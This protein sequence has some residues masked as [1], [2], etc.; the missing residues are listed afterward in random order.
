MATL[1]LRGIRVIEMGF[2]VA[3]PFACALLADFGAEVIKIEP[4]GAGDSMRRMGPAKDGVGLWWSVAARSKKSVTIDIRHER[5]QQLIKDLVARSDVLVENFR[6]GVLE[7]YG[8]G[9]EQLGAVNPDLIMLRISGFGQTG[10]LANRPGFGKI[11]E[12]FS[13]ATQ[14]TGPRDGAPLHPGYSLADLT[15][16]LMGAFAVMIALFARQNRDI[17]GELIDLA[18]YEPLFRMIEW[19]I[20]LWEQLGQLPQRDGPRFPFG[21]SFL[22]NICRTSDDRYVV[23]SAATEATIARVIAL[24]VAEGMLEAPLAPLEDVGRVNRLLEQWIA[25]T[26][27]S[28][29][30]AKLHEH[31]VVADMIYTAADLYEHEHIRA[32]GNLVT[33]DHPVLGRITMPAPVPKFGNLDGNVL[34]PGPELGEHTEEVLMRVLGLGEAEIDCLRLLGVI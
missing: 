26:P 2:A 20:P 22:V 7:R 6:P 28:E 4:P 14:L 17:R 21:Q 24:L 32:R 13:G 30:L 27:A 11:G 8:L 3:G 15:T 19:Q 1:P 10:P 34:W 29:A 12:S 16:G 9:W 23:V 5:G 18:L 25:R 33:L 31:D